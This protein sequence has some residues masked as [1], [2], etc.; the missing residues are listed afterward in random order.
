MDYYKIPKTSAWEG[1]Y[2]AAPRYNK[3]KSAGYIVG[4][5]VLFAFL[6]RS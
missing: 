4:I 2:R 6:I 5:L 1:P 3:L